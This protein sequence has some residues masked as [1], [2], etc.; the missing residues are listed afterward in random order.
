MK[1]RYLKHGILPN[2]VRLPVYLSLDEGLNCNHKISATSKVQGFYNLL[3]HQAR[4][5]PSKEKP[6]QS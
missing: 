2:I 6:A 4:F 5:S 3:L 1:E